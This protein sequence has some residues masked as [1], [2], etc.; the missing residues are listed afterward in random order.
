MEKDEIVKTLQEM[1]LEA[2]KCTGNLP[3]QI[4]QEWVI[5]ILLG[6]KIKE[7]GGNPYSYKE[8]AKP[9]L[10]NFYFTFGSASTFPYERGYLIVRAYDIK[11]A[12]KKFRGKY[13]DRTAGTLNCA[14]YYTQTQWTNLN[15]NKDWR[16]CHEVI[17]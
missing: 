2:A 4:S 6:E 3:G 16:I 1:Q 10:E 8:H 15:F 7:L 14:D 13:P 5:N 17:E 11:S 12:F 9:P